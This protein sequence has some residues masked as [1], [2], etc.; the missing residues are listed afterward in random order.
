MG[1]S[2]SPKIKTEKVSLNDNTETENVRLK[3]KTNVVTSSDNISA[4]GTSAPI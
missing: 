3:D 1:K 2:K 4:I